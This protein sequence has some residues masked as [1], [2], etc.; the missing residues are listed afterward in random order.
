MTTIGDIF[1]TPAQVHQV[2]K[3]AKQTPVPVFE[4]DMPV[5]DAGDMR[6][7]YDFRGGVRG[8]HAKDLS[9]GYTTIVHHKDGTREVTHY[10]PL[11]DMVHLAPDVR[12]YFPD[13]ESVNTALRGLIAL[14]PAKRRA[15][16]RV[17]EE[18]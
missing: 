5:V 4:A 1:A 12:V 15:R 9:K 2:M 11:P 17:H 6:P 10:R 8:Q 7:E 18:R 3:Q 16:R 14:I 13:S